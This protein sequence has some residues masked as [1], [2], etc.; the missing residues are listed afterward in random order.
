M[1]VLNEILHTSAA[2]SGLPAKDAVFRDFVQKN[3]YGNSSV[4]HVK[5]THMKQCFSL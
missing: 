1:C 5:V 4:E 2:V 3:I